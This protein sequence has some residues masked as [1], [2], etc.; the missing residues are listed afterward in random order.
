MTNYFKLGVGVLAGVLVGGFMQ[1]A[2]AQ[3]LVI[4]GHKDCSQS[5]AAQ[6]TMSACIEC[7]VTRSSAAPTQ[8]QATSW[9]RAHQ[10][11]CQ[12]AGGHGYQVPIYVRR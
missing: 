1:A 5:C 3:N 11:K 9:C 12:A 2:D 6:P 8:A 4:G 7:N 10:P